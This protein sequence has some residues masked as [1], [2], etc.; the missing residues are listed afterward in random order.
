MLL[1]KD[2]PQN[3]QFI[4]LSV[5]IQVDT[6]FERKGIVLAVTAVIKRPQ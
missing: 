5:S 1:K 6:Y 4:C 3:L 2:S